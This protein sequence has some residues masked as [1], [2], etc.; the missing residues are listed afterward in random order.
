M[1]M[2]N[3]DLF[4]TYKSGCK[5][6]EKSLRSADRLYPLFSL[7]LIVA[8]RV[9]FILQMSRVNPRMSS[10]IF[11]E[12]SEWKAGYA[13]AMRSRNVPESPPT[14]EEMMQYI[15]KLGGYLGRKNDPP[16]GIKAIWMGICKLTNYA[17]AWDIF[18]PGASK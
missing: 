5:V 9:N 13:A 16:P 1:P 12:E 8:W 11:F 15:A 17:D 10:E 4:K 3:R 6:E 7:L 14:M 2:G 18:G